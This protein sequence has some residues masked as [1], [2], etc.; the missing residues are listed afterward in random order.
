MEPLR[1]ERTGRGARIM[2]NNLPFIWGAQYYRAPTPEPDCWERDLRRMREL[3]FDSVKFWVQWRWSCRE[4][5]RFE[6]DDLDRL[7]ELAHRSGLRVTLNLIMDTAPAWLFR[8][9]PDA[10]QMTDG[11]EP[12]EPRAVASRQ[13][14]GFPGPC[15]THPGALAERKRFLARTVER[16]R[17]HP[18]LEL[19][20]VWNEP[21]QCGPYRSPAAGKLVCYCNS[22]RAAFLEWLRKKYRTIQALNEV[23]GRCYRGW[24]EV[25]P[26]LTGETI[27]DFIDYREFRLDVMTAEARWR[28][29]LT[30]ELDP[31]HPA[32]LHVVPNTMRIFNSLTGVDDFALARLCG[33]F[34][35]T[36]FAAPVWPL[37][38]VSAGRG[39]FCYNAE[40][41]IAHGSIG[42]HQ[43]V[44]GLEELVGELVPQIG[45]GLR[46]FMFWQYRPE[47]LGTEAPA[48]GLVRPDGSDRPL[49]AAVEAFRNTIGPYLPTIAATG[50]EE[51]VAGIWSGRKNE[52]FHWAAMRSAETPAE[53]LEAYAGFFYWNS[54]PCRVIDSMTLERGELGAIRLL[55]MPACY[56]LTGA[57]AAA[58][59]R[60]VRER[61]GTLVCEA[62][63]GGWN[64]DTGR[65]SRVTPGFGLAEAWNIRE[66]ETTSTHH[67]GFADRVYSPA[68]GLPADLRKA[69]EA[70]GTDGG[71]YVPV[72][73]STGKTVWG[74]D[75]FAV[76]DAPGAE[77]LG[78][79]GGLPCIVRKRVGAGTVVY[80]GTNLGAAGV[81]DREGFTGF[82][83]GI[84]RDAGLEPS[85]GCEPDVP[86][87]V[88]L[89]AL[90][91]GTDLRAI[92]LRNRSDS[93]RRVKL[94]C[95]GS[96]RGVFT[97]LRFDAD[98]TAEL[99]LPPGFT[100]LLVSG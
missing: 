92:V 89:D 100:D 22:C 39:K 60:W 12:V 35:A 5:D 62:H 6:F 76:L 80:C 18:A 77:V 54:L 64:A 26:P 55:V 82:L 58:I 20:D 88:R 65:H 43:K 10:L 56:C 96:F 67:L 16:F 72:T 81:P 34:G 17:A 59:E 31:T 4:P 48:W 75:R 19:W 87:S 3:G 38:T 15:Y 1:P 99:T 66:A 14:G 83:T 51:P 30:R 36:A 8:T 21:E 85:C 61:G 33:L 86:G 45:A 23:W 7:M 50:P 63:L 28:I 41:H 57:E 52:L 97:G 49:T 95:R 73:L 32:H 27:I 53:A 68:G 74:A 2:R 91:A 98:G 93:E 44:T 24:D 42:M 11:S 69:I 78:N 79:A 29:E 13:I 46:G 70:L 40:C 47:S 25:E 37:L 84:C 9:Y 90:R 71:R 94:R